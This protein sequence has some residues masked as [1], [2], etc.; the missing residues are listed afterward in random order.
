MVYFVGVGWGWG[1]EGVWVFFGQVVGGRSCS[2]E[3]A[4]CSALT[5]C[6]SPT[7]ERRGRGEISRLEKWV[8]ERG[9]WAF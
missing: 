4:I 2:L 7:E 3:C 6:P 1:L 9:C 8:L 5:P